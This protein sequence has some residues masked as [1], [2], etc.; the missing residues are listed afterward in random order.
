M[1]KTLLFS[2]IAALALLA[3]CTASKGTT[4]DQS[5]AQTTAAPMHHDYKGER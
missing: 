5:S 3:G 4:S 1:E 2:V